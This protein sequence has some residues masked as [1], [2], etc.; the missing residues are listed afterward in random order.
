MRG[1]RRPTTRPGRSLLTRTSPT[2][3]F[4][5]TN[6]IVRVT[7][8]LTITKSV[9]DT[10]GVVLSTATFT[11]DYSCQYGTEAP[12]Q[13]RWTIQ[14]SV[15]P[16]FSVPGILLTSVSAVTEDTPDPAGLA[17]SS[18]TWAPPVVSAPVPVTRGDTATITVT[19]APERL[20]GGLELTKTV[21]DPAGGVKPGTVY[22]GVWTC[23]DGTGQDAVRTRTGSRWP[24]VRQSSSSRP[25]TPGFRPARSARSR[26]TR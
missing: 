17:N 11:G 2:Q 26:R 24:P 3:L 5:A 20:Y 4:L 14:P 19:N 18:W 12:V 21:I 16:T 25:P 9:N 13:G 7:G 6:P 23:L 1:D 8:S 22:T 15:E 10:S